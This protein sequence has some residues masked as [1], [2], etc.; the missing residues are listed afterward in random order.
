VIAAGILFGGLRLGFTFGGDDRFEPWHVVEGYGGFLRLLLGL[1]E[2]AL[3]WACLAGAHLPVAR[4]F[5]GLGPL[6]LAV[7]NLPPDVLISSR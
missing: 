7:G 3:A 6:R 4:Y 5:P 2:Q 1:P